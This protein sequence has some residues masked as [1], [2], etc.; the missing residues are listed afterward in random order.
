[1]QCSG[2][3]QAFLQNLRGQNSEQADIADPI[4]SVLIKKLELNGNPVGFLENGCQ[5]Y[6]LVLKDYILITLL[7][8][9]P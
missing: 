1:M 2:H 9:Y 4:T 5:K 8:D 6:L 7:Y 3:L